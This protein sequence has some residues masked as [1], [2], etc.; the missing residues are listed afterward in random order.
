MLA[1]YPIAATDHN[2]ISVTLLSA[3]GLALEALQQGNAP[4]EFKD[5]ISVEHRAE[6]ARGP[7]FQGL[8]DAFVAKCQGLTPDECAQVAA[9]L[10]EQNNLPA[11]FTSTTSCSSIRGVFPEVHEA[12]KELFKHA[13]EKLSAW[14]AP[15]SE[16]TIRATYHRLVDAH[17]SHGS[18]PFCGYEPLEAVDPDLVDPDLDHY[19]AISIYPFAG[20]NLRNLTAMG[21]N[22]NRS[23]KGAQD[24]LL[25][26]HN[27]RVDC[28]DPYGNEQVTLSLAG[29]AI[30]SDG[31]EGPAWAI[32]FD[33]DVKSRNWRRIF[34][35]ETRLR[36]SVLARQ[37]KKWLQHCIT[38]AQA[39]GIDVSTKDGALEAVGKFKKTCAFE[40]FPTIGLLK[41]SFF[42]LIESALNDPVGGERMHN[43][44]VKAA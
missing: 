41:T 34:E 36:S 32:T 40:T 28:F 33:P 21:A 23:Y 24:I 27:Q 20:V 29:T 17:L 18:C 31:G 37:Y 7:K 38:Y 26:Q 10:V 39:N 4:P 14:K 44:L 1:T 25:D 15:G 16:Q 22:C 12:A 11:V 2:W 35:L 8:Y 9:A 13:F 5:A 43:F 6:F 42:D 30:L 3:L 19:L